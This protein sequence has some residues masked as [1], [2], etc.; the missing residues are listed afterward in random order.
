MRSFGTVVLFLGIVVIIGFM[1]IIVPCFFGMLMVMG[2]IAM[3][4]RLA[5]ASRNSGNEDY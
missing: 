4:M 1:I 5:Y 3:V 2:I